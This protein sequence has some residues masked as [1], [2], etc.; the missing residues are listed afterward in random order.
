MSLLIHD[1]LFDLSGKRELRLSAIENGRLIGVASVANF[2]R[3]AGTIFQLFV[4]PDVRGKGVGTALVR[5]ACQ[6]AKDAGAGAMSAIVEPGGPMGFWGGLGFKAAH[7]DGPN[8]LVV[9]Q[10]E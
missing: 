7:V 8:L 2:G 6:Q 10:L 3:S 4:R 5:V 1:M 9:K